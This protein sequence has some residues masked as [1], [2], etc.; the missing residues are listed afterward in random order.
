MKKFYVLLA[1]LVVTVVAV[2]AGFACCSAVY[3][4]ETR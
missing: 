2:S 1:A 3:E 4:P